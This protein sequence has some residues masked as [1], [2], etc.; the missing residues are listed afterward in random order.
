VH[1]YTY[2]YIVFKTHYII[3]ADYI[4]L[5]GDDE[6]VINMYYVDVSRSVVTII[7]NK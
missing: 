1:K 5:E 3:A 4:Y 6:C 7:R 2:T